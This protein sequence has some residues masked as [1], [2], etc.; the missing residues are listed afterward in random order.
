MRQGSEERGAQRRMGKIREVQ[1]SRG[2]GARRA[3]E[4]VLPHEVKYDFDDAHLVA[5]GHVL[6]RPEMNGAAEA[7]SELSDRRASFPLAQHAHV[8]V[9]EHALD[10]RFGSLLHSPRVAPRPVGRMNVPQWPMR[11][12]PMT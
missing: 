5:H 7:P 9:D 8:A 6:K 2:F 4:A 11:A 3:R 1:T 12:S 10:G